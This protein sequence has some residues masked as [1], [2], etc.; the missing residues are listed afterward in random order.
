MTSTIEERVVEMK[1]DNQEFERNVK[2]SINTLDKL[3]MALDLDGAAKGF[4]E[5]ARA[6]NKVDLSNID[7]AAETVQVKFSA[8]QIA[9]MTAIQELT[10]SFLNFGKSIWNMSFG[11]MKSGGMA[12][13]LK[14][15]QAT[16]KMKALAKNIEGIGDSEE[17]INALLDEMG[18]KIDDA[19]TGTAYGY[20]AAASVAS[21]LMASGMTDAE[22]M[23]S[24]LRGIAGAAAMTG[25][26][27]EDIGNIFTTIASN[28]KLMTMQLRQF[29]A[30]GLNVSAELARQWGKTEAEVNDM[31]SHGKVGF[32]EFADAMYDAFGESAGKADETYS[33]VL[34]N[35]KA[36]LSRIG[37]L[38][39][40]PYIQ[41]MIPVL[42]N[43]KATLKSLKNALTP[44][45]ARV[46]KFMKFASD[47]MS[48]FLEGIDFS[49]LEPMFIG[50]ENIFWSLAMVI[51]A[52]RR[53]FAEMFPP[54]TTEELRSAAV[55]FQRFTEQLVPSRKALNGITGIV[56]ALL[57]PVKAIVALAKALLKSSRP[58]IVMIFRLIYGV[59][60]LVGHLGTVA[61][62]IA[63]IIDASGLFDTIF[64][65]I[66][67]TL[68]VVIYL[69]VELVEI[70]DQVVSA[71]EKSGVG[72]RFVTVIKDTISLINRMLVGVLV[73][74]LELVTKIFEHIKVENLVLVVE[75]VVNGLGILVGLLGWIF[76]SLLSG[77]DVLLHSDTIIGRLFD[78]IKSVVDLIVSFFKKEDTDKKITN[79][80][81]ALSRLKDKLREVGN[82]ISTELKKINGKDVIIFAFTIVIMALVVSVVNLIKNLGDLVYTTNKVV[83]TFSTIANTA[84]SIKNV[85]ANAKMFMYFAGSIVLITGSL[86]ELSKIPAD[87]LLPAAAVL[88][89]LGVSMVIFSGLMTVAMKKMDMF[90]RQSNGVKALAM[91]MVSF[92]LGVFALTMSLR[93]LSE[94]NIDLKSTVKLLAIMVATIASF[95]AAA[96]IMSKKVGEF[97]SLAGAAI[98]FVSFA[99]AIGILI[100]SLKKVSDLDLTESWQN[101][102]ILGGMVTAIGVAIRAAAGA[103]VG[104]GL[105]IFAFAVLLDTIAKAFVKIITIDMTAVMVGIENLKTIFW[106]LMPVLTVMSVLSRIAGGKQLGLGSLAGFILGVTVFIFIITNSLLRLGNIPLTQL[107][108]AT[109]VINSVLG[110]IT[111]AVSALVI[112]MGLINHF[113]G[114]PAVTSFERNKEKDKSKTTYQKAA[115]SLKGI[116]G[117]ILALTAS[118][119]IL[120]AAI[121]AA[122]KIPDPKAFWNAFGRVMAVMAAVTAAVMAL[123]GMSHFTGNS[124]TRSVVV[125]MLG[126]LVILGMLLGGIYM[127]A[128][129]SPGKASQIGNLMYRFTWLI[130]V[131]GGMLLAMTKL[132]KAALV[133]LTTK[134]V[135]ATRADTAELLVF[136]LGISLII[137][138]VGALLYFIVNNI[139]TIEEYEVDKMLLAVLGGIGVLFMALAGATMILSKSKFSVKDIKKIAVMFGLLEVMFIAMMAPIAALAYAVQK[140]EIDGDDV[141]VVGMVVGY[142]GAMMA[143]IGL[144]GLLISHID[145]DL[146]DV[147]WAGN[148]REWSAPLLKMSV[149]ILS[150]GVIFAV[151]SAAVTNILKNLDLHSEQSIHA[152]AWIF[153]GYIVLIGEIAAV[154][155]IFG[156]SDS[157][158][159]PKNMLATAGAITMMMLSL[160][161]MTIALESLSHVY[162]KKLLKSAGSLALFIVGLSIIL[163]IINKVV[164][165]NPI[166]SV[167]ML[168]FAGSIVIMSIAMLVIVEALSQMANIGADPD[169][170]LAY[171]GALNGVIFILGLVLAAAGG[172]T[173]F[174]WQSVLGIGGMAVGFVVFAAAMI[175]VAEALGELQKAFPDPDDMNK[176]L[177]SLI[178]FFGIFGALSGVVGLVGGIFGP[179]VS[180]AIISLGAAIL[181]LGSS[182]NKVG[183][184][185]LKWVTAMKELTTF[186]PEDTENM[187]RNLVEGVKGMGDAAEEFRNQLPKFRRAMNGI[188]GEIMAVLVQWLPV[189]LGIWWI[190]SHAS[191]V[192]FILGLVAMIDPLKNLLALVAQSLYEWIDTGAGHNTF[193]QLGYVLGVAITDGII[194]AFNGIASRIARVVNGE[195]G[196][197]SRE[198]LLASDDSAQAV[199]DMFIPTAFDDM[200]PFRR[201]QEGAWDAI[202]IGKE[203]QKFVDG[204]AE[205][206]VDLDIVISNTERYADALDVLH[207]GYDGLSEAFRSKEANQN[208]LAVL[209]SMLSVSDT[210]Q[211]A[212]DDLTAA[213][214][215]GTISLAQYDRAMTQ[216]A[217]TAKDMRHQIDYN[218]NESSVHGSGARNMWASDFENLRDFADAVKEQR[219]SVLDEALG[220]DHKTVHN[221][222][223][224]AA[225][226]FV[227]GWVSRGR[228][229]FGGGGGGGHNA[230]NNIVTN[231]LVGTRKDIRRIA[232]DN[233]TEYADTFAETAVENAETTSTDVGE[234]VSSGFTSFF[235]E[236]VASIGNSFSGG[237]D[238]T[239]EKAKELMESLDSVIETFELPDLEIPIKFNFLGL[240]SSS[241][242]LEE[243]NQMVVQYTR[244]SSGNITGASRVAKW[245]AEGYESAEAYAEAHSEGF[246]SALEYLGIDLDEDNP[247]KGFTDS[248]QQSVEEA[249]QGM[250]N[251]S[252]AASSAA[253]KTDELA[254]SIANALDI[255][256]G[257][258]VELTMTSRDVLR[259][260][261]EQLYGVANWS[262]ELSSLAG[263]GIS[264]AVLE[265]LANAGPE[266]Y[267]RV[268]ALYTMSA[269]ELT[270][271]NKMYEQ[272]LSLESSTAD[273]IRQSFESG[274]GVIISS[275]EALGGEITET[276][277]ESVSEGTEQVVESMS[278]MERGVTDAGYE[279]VNGV[280]MTG[281]DIPKE[282]EEAIKAGAV[283]VA[284]AFGKLGLNSIEAFKH[285]MDVEDAILSV[286]MFQESLKETVA[287]S[288]SLFDELGEQEEISSE[289]ML[290]NMKEQLK[291]VGKW[292]SGLRTLAARG[293]DEG[294]L[295]ELQALGPA[296]AAKVQAF[297]KMSDAQLDKANRLYQDKAQLP[298]YVTDK[299]T[300]SYA[301]AGYMTTLGFVEGIDPSAAQEVMVA[302]GT[303]SLD[304]LKEAL[305]IHSP[306]RKTAE[307][308]M[309]TVMG[310]VAGITENLPMIAE[311][312]AAMGNTLVT[313]ISAAPEVMAEKVGAFFGT[314]GEALLMGVENFRESDTM[315]YLKKVMYDI[316]T[317]TAD[318]MVLEP[319][320][321]PV[322]D[323]SNLDYKGGALSKWFN[324]SFDITPAISGAYN[325]SSAA[326]TDYSNV[327][328]DISVTLK[329][330]RDDVVGLREDV[331]NLQTVMDGVSVTMDGAAV[332]KLTAPYVNQQLG[333]TYNYDTRRK[334]K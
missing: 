91:V 102:L 321:R 216:I 302:L 130:A 9:G 165:K 106:E 190:I 281:R 63:E 107:I 242:M 191:T 93:I 297:V 156:N 330:T 136:V 126:L 230:V 87:R 212:V 265:D 168:A 219:Q 21:Q 184:G 65:I 75:G 143:V 76:T 162:W 333:K 139:E 235:T 78:T 169:D 86:N 61:S 305:D 251:Y 224:Q 213:Y 108:N 283:P 231:R 292:A 175:K 220:I 202:E 94:T 26:S 120:T 7:K 90:D 2:T 315:I 141:A 254:D 31:I 14:I 313:A 332:G 206:N 188:L 29:S 252:D 68:T 256:S 258:N 151:I 39:A 221:L 96:I 255:F 310:L 179:G 144:L 312:A 69:F 291:N 301:E 27:F 243:A 207:K 176:Y 276:I 73:V 250:N 55:T 309:F 296:G 320:I 285:Y 295:A 140:Y 316:L 215:N 324:G 3:K 6:A 24:W 42:Q 101:I 79:V 194:G 201:L 173:A 83:S 53:G 303:Q 95:T 196:N 311:A 239:Q 289:K 51:E 43:L 70:L 237:S 222:G 155:A 278:E 16:F 114:N 225:D 192:M 238:A 148:P 171:A 137:A 105:A 279:I 115:N 274:E 125:Q 197:T 56:K 123:E 20:D 146:S 209:D 109:N 271:F 214:E 227:D 314:L 22:K 322:I 28:G 186:T 1:F 62:A 267:D 273:R 48:A 293:M 287:G 253:D 218:L 15:E 260:F 277:A 264:Q 204:L 166:D 112:I 160:Y 299:L 34:S 103:T 127:F 134:S 247:I 304:S 306:S 133:D 36:Q 67:N 211:R 8:M 129:L 17:K 284:D 142:V 158:I 163:V 164:L 35:V 167:G 236:V 159:D 234:K 261:T 298:Q 187:K 19:V 149:V 37:Q 11:Q 203:Y 210:L 99:I 46:E 257:F 248:L 288:I 318:D 286:E 259:S 122:S 13:A 189:I 50:L 71:F 18:K 182:V 249:T 54:K 45:A 100:S 145:Q 244:D 110:G 72:Q 223:K 150:F 226:D 121:D 269:S 113:N 152:L 198:L 195:A 30:S 47:K 245:R 128:W 52:V 282:M 327:L 217:D 117:I 300:K 329:Q 33:G 58:I 89:T 178:K 98:G 233:A 228:T 325:G 270:L 92:A 272:K 81:E 183:D 10:R 64:Q 49:R 177:D 185:I 153:I 229:E 275:A 82:A 174:R 205:G 199:H 138:E 294:L 232:Q 4:N 77:I 40:E 181:F 308:G 66:G 118:V 135:E 323:T 240:G 97:K 161:P 193:Y 208:N 80:S 5:I 44:I 84:K 180:I 57:V 111:T 268:H 38:F 12:R 241:K 23:Y 266:A 319:T 263:K 262:N 74:I 290:Q 119:V 41:N 326:K 32:Q 200:G 280:I 116:A 246:K 317:S 132:P 154:L 331:T 328:R 334:M 172:L 157:S 124:K 88:V 104:T 59:L 307:T 85:A 60:S 131:L 170:L 25:R 147:D